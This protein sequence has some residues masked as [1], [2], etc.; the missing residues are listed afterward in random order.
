MKRIR[1]FLAKDAGSPLA[2]ALVFALWLVFGIPI[3]A[4]WVRGY[5]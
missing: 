5:W 2:W 3:I 1:Y 4:G